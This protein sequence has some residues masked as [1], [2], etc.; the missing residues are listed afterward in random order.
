LRSLNSVAKEKFANIGRNFMQH[1]RNE[2]FVYSQH[3]IL[4]KSNLI[5]IDTRMI[6]EYHS[7]KKIGHVVTL[8]CWNREGKKEISNDYSPLETLSLKAPYG[9]KYLFLLPVWMIYILVKLLSMKY[10]YIQAINFDSYIPSL[11]AAKI[12]GKPIVYEMEDTYADQISMP[13]FLRNTILRFDKFLSKFADAII[14]VDECQLREFNGLPNSNVHVIYDAPPDFA[15]DFIKSNSSDETFKIF[16]PGVFFRARQLN[17]DKII[18]FVL[19]TD[20]VQLTI[21]GYGDMKDE[22][23]EL[24]NKVPNKIKYVGWVE[25]R[26]D[27]FQMMYNSDLT[28]AFKDIVVPLNRYICGSKVFEAMMCSVPIIVNA[29]TSVAMKVK[30]HNCGVV[31]DARNQS[32]VDNALLKLIEDRQ[33]CRYLGDNG[34]RAYMGLYRWDVMER[35]LFSLYQ[36]LKCDR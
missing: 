11:I 12:R 10:D 33:Y 23:I 15:C 25:S 7:L 22:I 9:V 31:V 3:V 26:A 35:K 4:L 1:N 14:L 36:G 24:A 34:R 18:D 32:E 16:Y 29:N 19:K 6:K 8:L 21:S 13:T 17:L 27:L 30:K 2:L 28:F 20:N 5:D